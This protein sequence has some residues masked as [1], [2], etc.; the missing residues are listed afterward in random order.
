MKISSQEIEKI[1][2]KN[3]VR[4]SQSK[5]EQK[6]DD[7][8]STNY[9]GQDNISGNGQTKNF[10]KAIIPLAYNVF[11]RSKT[12]ALKI[13]KSKEKF[14]FEEKKQ[15]KNKKKYAL[16][17]ISSS[18]D[19]GRSKSFQR[20]HSFSNLSSTQYTQTQNTQ[21][22]KFERH[23]TLDSNKKLYKKF[24]NSNNNTPKH[25]NQNVFMTKTCSSKMKKRHFNTRQPSKIIDTANSSLI[26]DR[27]I[28]CSSSAKRQKKN[29]R[30]PSQMKLR[31]F[32]KV[33]TLAEVVGL[34]KTNDDNDSLKSKIVTQKHYLFDNQK[35]GE[36]KKAEILNLKQTFSEYEL[37][38]LPIPLKRRLYK[39]KRIKSASNF[40]FGDLKS[41]IRND[42]PCL[43]Q[44]REDI[45]DSDC[46]GI[47]KVFQHDIEEK[48][49]KNFDK[50]L[51]QFYLE[52]AE[53]NK[54]MAAY[55]VESGFWKRI[56]KM[57]NQ[58]NK[59][60]KSGREKD[61]EFHSKKMIKQHFDSMT[62]IRNTKKHN[63]KKREIIDK[64]KQDQKI[65][66]NSKS[67][68][69]KRTKS[70]GAFNFKP[71]PN[72]RDIILDHSDFLGLETVKKYKRFQKMESRGQLSPL[73]LNRRNEFKTPLIKI[74]KDQSQIFRNV[75]KHLELTIQDISSENLWLQSKLNKG[76]SIKNQQMSRFQFESL[77][78]PHNKRIS[79]FVQDHSNLAKSTKDK[80]FE[81]R[82]RQTPNSIYDLVNLQME[83]KK[84]KR[85]EER[86]TMQQLKEQKESQ[87]KICKGNI[88]QYRSEVSISFNN[89]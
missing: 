42:E 84:R 64:I 66:K 68:N 63:K 85:E 26:L 75:K 82:K 5:H 24:G 45:L 80:E 73:K 12:A 55:K 77:A 4:Q 43:S 8:F 76:F 21:I 32:Q 35:Y 17:S 72:L 16:F 28:H 79:Q 29:P 58:K 78:E 31:A 38:C 3:I 65:Q 14:G 47:D 61:S 87:S 19:L 67:K 34:R 56:M 70:H 13:K 44:K 9:I 1:T 54:Q 53:Q 15:Q 86:T 71:K 49:I 88:G 46:I 10:Q 25:K 39:K 18:K 20:N 59:D 52:A 57:K 62:F 33:K 40:S 74:E 11:K 83:I 23:Q 69:H 81:A 41:A 37:N 2:Q 51:T 48:L 7:T 36:Y 6:V 27:S 60:Q 30:V 22:K 50:K 89:S